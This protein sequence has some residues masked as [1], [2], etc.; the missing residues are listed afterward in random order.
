M[1]ISK[2]EVDKILKSI[3]LIAWAFFFPY[4]YEYYNVSPDESGPQIYKIFFPLVYCF[5]MI[6][7]GTG[8]YFIYTLIKERV[9]GDKKNA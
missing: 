8:C 9:S 3:M 1:K 5:C 7:F 4:F 6:S 2:K